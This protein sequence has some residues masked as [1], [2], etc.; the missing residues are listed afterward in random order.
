MR[1]KSKQR[2]DGKKKTKVVK[3]EKG[4]NKE[5]KYI[6]PLTPTFIHQK[7]QKLIYQKK[8]KKR[9]KLQKLL[10]SVCHATPETFQLVTIDQWRSEEIYGARVKNLLQ[11]HM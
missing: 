8:K 6:I 7:L 5:K 2:L 11:I 3:M 4:D 1:P 9:K 10:K